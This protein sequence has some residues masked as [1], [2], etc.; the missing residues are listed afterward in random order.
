MAARKEL[1]GARTANSGLLARLNEAL[2]EKAALQLHIQVV[3]LEGPSPSRPAPPPP[4]P[5]HVLPCVA[6]WGGGRRGS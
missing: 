5:A 3:Q 1:S 2:A 4:S 6:V